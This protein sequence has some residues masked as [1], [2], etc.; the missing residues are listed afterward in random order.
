MS[1]TN[2]MTHGVAHG[3]FHVE[4]E[5]G[6]GD[7]RFAGADN[8]RRD[9]VGLKPPMCGRW[10]REQEV[11]RGSMFRVE[12]RQGT[13]QMFRTTGEWVRDLKRVSQSM[14]VL[15]QEIGDQDQL[16]VVPSECV[17]VE[18][19]DFH[20]PLRWTRRGAGACDESPGVSPTIAD[21]AFALKSAQREVQGGAA[22]LEF[23]CEQAFGRKSKLPASMENFRAKS[24]AET[25]RERAF[26]GSDGVL[27]RFFDGIHGIFKD[28]FFGRGVF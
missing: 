20:S 1:V 4:I 22:D 9:V 15:A 12:L 3:G 18:Q 24:F 17:M 28:G 11:E 27:V 19:H 7:F 8:H 13:R 23:V 16:G 21:E 14:Q 25:I 10:N 6:E 26:E 5:G 2:E